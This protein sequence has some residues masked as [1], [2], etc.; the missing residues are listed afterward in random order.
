[1]DIGTSDNS[2]ADLSRQITDG[3]TKADMSAL[4]GGQLSFN[5]SGELYLNGDT[6]VSAGIQNALKSIIGEPRMIPIYKSVANPG[7]TATYTICQFVGI[8]VLNVKLTGALKLKSVTIQ[9]AY[10]AMKGGIANGTGNSKYVYSYNVWL[11][12]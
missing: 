3:V 6:G 12:R 2:T 5:S 4:P 7:N 8:R 10:V 11:V 9:P 1:V